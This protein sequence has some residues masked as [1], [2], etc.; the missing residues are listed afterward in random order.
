MFKIVKFTYSPHI[1][2]NRLSM[3][4]FIM[5]AMYMTV[6]TAI[7]LTE[8]YVAEALSSDFFEYWLSTVVCYFWTL[9][10]IMTCFEWEI[11]T[12]LV[13]F[14]MKCEIQVMGI[15]KHKFNN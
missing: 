2:K 7:F 8:F 4:P 10:I 14:Q 6:I 15:E 5:T 3:V 1:T 12:S 9:I 13:K 11:I